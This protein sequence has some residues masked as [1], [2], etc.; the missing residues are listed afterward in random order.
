MVLV[1]QPARSVERQIHPL[2]STRDGDT[3]GTSSERA[4]TSHR[5]HSLPLGGAPLG[6]DGGPDNSTGNNMQG[7]ALI[8]LVLKSELAACVLWDGGGGWEDQ[9]DV[10]I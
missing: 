9:G 1:E 6:P 4:G 8:V 3:S 5:T 2:S 10:E 7:L